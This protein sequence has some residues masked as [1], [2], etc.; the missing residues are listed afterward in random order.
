MYEWPTFEIFARPAL[1]VFRK[2]YS[3]QLR[4][5]VDRHLHHR[6]FDLFTAPD[7]VASQDIHC[8]DACLVSF[9]KTQQQQGGP[10]NRSD[11][12]FVEFSIFATPESFASLSINRV[13]RLF[14]ARHDNAH[15][16][17]LVKAN[18]FIEFCRPRLAKNRKGREQ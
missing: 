2:D 4:A 13:E 11:V 12:G 15:F 10:R 16:S 7:R 6:A 3:E 5:R 18:V 8:L 1:R 9:F 17:R 14:R